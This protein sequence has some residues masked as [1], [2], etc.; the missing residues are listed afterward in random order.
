M[1]ITPR[2]ILFIFAIFVCTQLCLQTP[3]SAATFTVTK[4]SDTYPIGQTGQLRWAI[5]RANQT[6]GTNQINFNIPG[7]GPFVIQPVHDLDAITNPVIINGYSQPGA[8]ENTLATGNNAHL[9]IAMYGANYATGNAYQ[10]SG[11]GLF[12]YQG[13][14]GSVVKGLVIS[15]WINNGI[16]VYNANNINIVGNFIGTKATGTAQLANQTGIFIESGNNT[17]I[18]SSIVT[19]IVKTNF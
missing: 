3:I 12:F 5:Q 9:L 7:T 11:N 2:K 18:G 1:R 10:G 16:V 14:D 13:S 4:T 19:P 8:T 15:A 6:A 17:T